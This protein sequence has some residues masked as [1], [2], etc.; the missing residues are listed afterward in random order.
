MYYLLGRKNNLLSVGKLMQKN[1]TIVF[2]E[3]GGRELHSDICLIM[4]IKISSNRMF[5]VS[6]HVILPMCMK[7]TTNN[8]T[9][10]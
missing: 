8:A 7:V 2:K 3:G 5:A 1:L 6:A 10:L 9:H 4:T